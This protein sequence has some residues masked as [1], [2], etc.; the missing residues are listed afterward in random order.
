MALRLDTIG[1]DVHGHRQRAVEKPR[2][3]LP[4]MHAY[5]FR[6]VNA[7]PSGNAN[8]AVLRLNVEIVFA[9]PWHLEND[10]QIVALLENVDRRE[11]ACSAGPASQP[12][13]LQPCLQRPLEVE[14]RVKGVVSSNHDHTSSLSSV[15]QASRAPAPVSRFRDVIGTVKTRVPIKFG[16][17]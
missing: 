4:A 2:P 12:V 10:N 1:I 3:A 14:E 9:D 5:A 17:L 15:E 16:E 8:D 11:G 13:A 7:F 6:I